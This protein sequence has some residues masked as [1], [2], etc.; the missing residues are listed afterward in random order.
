VD[1]LH[2]GVMR[3]SLFVSSGQVTKNFLCF[4]DYW[5]LNFCEDFFKTL[6]YPDA[7]DETKRID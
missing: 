7:L 5:H 6:I 3:S 2:K 4:Y 1:G